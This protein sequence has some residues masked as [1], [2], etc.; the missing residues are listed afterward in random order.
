MEN[1]NLSIIN[2]SQTE[3]NCSKINNNDN[4]S[5]GK[6]S[7]KSSESLASVNGKPESNA[8]KKSG[9]LLLE[10]KKSNIDKFLENINNRKNSNSSKNVKRN[11]KVKIQT[12]SP[13]L[14]NSILHMSNNNKSK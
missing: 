2:E 3:A 4:K 5:E 9:F 6:H 12:D 14:P 13:K 8:V 1:S 7:L 11:K 10:T